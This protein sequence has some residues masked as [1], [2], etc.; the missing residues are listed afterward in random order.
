M[1]RGLTASGSFDFLFE[2]KN[3]MVCSGGT[4]Y[5]GITGSVTRGI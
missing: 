2:R 5:A 3:R 1:S 4:G